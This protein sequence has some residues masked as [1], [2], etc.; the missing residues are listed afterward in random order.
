MLL[1]SFYC[2]PHLGQVVV[3]RS[4]S[5]RLECANEHVM[6]TSGLQSRYARRLHAEA[7][8]VL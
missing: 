7:S 3:T 6:T 4:Q 8:K 2:R 1:P 5:G